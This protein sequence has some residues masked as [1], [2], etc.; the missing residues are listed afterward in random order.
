MPHHRWRQRRAGPNRRPVV[1]GHLVIQALRESY[2]GSSQPYTS[3]RLNTSRLFETTYG[4]FEARIRLPRGTGLWPAFWLLGAN[5]GTVGWPACG[6]IDVMEEAG[7]HPTIAH[8]TAIGSNAMYATSTYAVPRGNL[9]DEYHLFALEW[10]SDTL[11]WFVDDV[12]YES[13]TRDDLAKAGVPW[14][15]DHPFY[16]ILNLAVGGTYDGAPT[17]GTVFPAQMFVDRVV[18]GRMP[19]L[20]AAT[21]RRRP[22]SRRRPA[23][24]DHARIPPW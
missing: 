11:K 23:R 16:M 3:G 10:G 5:F 1:K 2:L 15:F 6:E 7:S 20:D 13:H 22:T 18:V 9:V 4:R 19:G 21:P 24:T 14:T 17:A 8:G 12:M